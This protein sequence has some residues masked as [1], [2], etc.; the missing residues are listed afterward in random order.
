MSN[1]T[2]QVWS[3]LLLKK[4]KLQ[5]I[6]AIRPGRLHIALT[7]I[8]RFDIEIVYLTETTESCQKKNQRRR[9]IRKRLKK[10]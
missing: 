6:N 8:N 4:E 5:E 9:A 3:D 10:I 1:P 7:N 2:P